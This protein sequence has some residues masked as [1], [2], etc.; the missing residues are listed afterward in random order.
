MRD[1][2]RALPATSLVT[3]PEVHLVDEV[4]N[5]IVMDDCGVHAVVLKDYL[6]ASKLSPSTARTVGAALGEFLARLHEWG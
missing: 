5:L 6:L 4:A 3:T 2:R 1:V